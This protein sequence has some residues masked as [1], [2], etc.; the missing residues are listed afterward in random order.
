MPGYK[1]HI[2]GGAIAYSILLIPLVSY[3]TSVTTAAGWLLCAIAGA[4]FPDVDIKSKGQKYFYRLL[5][6]IFIVLILEKK[7]DLLAIMSLLSLVPMLVKH[8]GLFH[9][10][11]F[12]I[13]LPLTLWFCMSLYFP[14]VTHELLLYIIF[15]I[16]GAISHL[17]L[18]LGLR[19][20]LRF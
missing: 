5:L 11:W 15:F 12:V 19:R 8:R 4:L 6:I 13:M 14:H 3:C 2:T 17:Y 16:A 7:F 9:R 10:L 1:G 18:D 20:M